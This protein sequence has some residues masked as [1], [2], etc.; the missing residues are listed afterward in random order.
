M[1]SFA[2]VPRGNCRADAPPLR[3]GSLREPPLRSGAS[4]FPSLLSTASRLSL[5]SQPWVDQFQSAEVGHFRSARTTVTLPVLI[6]FESRLAL[7][8][9]V[10]T[11][12]PRVTRKSKEERRP[13][14]RDLGSGDRPR[15]S[16]S[17]R[18]VGRCLERLTRAVGRQGSALLETD[19]KPSYRSIL[20]RFDSGR[21][22][23]HAAYSGKLPRGK[24]NPLFPINHTLAMIRDGL[25]RLRRRTWCHSKS[26]LRLWQH[27]G[28]Y[29]AWKNFVRV[30]FNGERKTPA[31]IAKV[32]KR[33]FGPS[34]L[35]RWRLDLGPVSISPLQAPAAA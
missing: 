12:A 15:R 2:L 18:V 19:R 1:P 4:A 7:A 13:P 33:R 34:E 28:I 8:A 25:S 9:E 29:F 16:Q 35:V 11:L 21:R 30:R 27:L 3:A 6:H 20:R 32:V 22:V 26:R 10:G 31:Q 17:N 23:S 5:L 14:G 24:K